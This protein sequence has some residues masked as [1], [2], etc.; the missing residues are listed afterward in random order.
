MGPW[1]PSGTTHSDAVG[2][3]RNSSTANSTGY[4]GS[5]SPCTINVRA[6]IDDS[7][8][9]VKFMSS[10]SLPNSRAWRHKARIWITDRR[11]LARPRRGLGIEL[12]GG[13]PDLRRKLPRRRTLHPRTRRVPTDPRIRRTPR[14]PKSHRRVAAVFVKGVRLRSCGASARHSNP[15]VNRPA[16]GAPERG[17]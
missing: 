13:A 10:R 6:V 12:A 5:R 15:P 8:V 3:A 4:S 1:P 9:G 14:R 17:A 16:S 7:V 11:I 2:I